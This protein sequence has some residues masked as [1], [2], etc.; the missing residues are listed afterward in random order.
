MSQPYVLNSKGSVKA[1]DTTTVYPP[2]D[3]KGRASRPPCKLARPGTGGTTAT[4]QEIAPVLRQRLLLAA[5]IMAAGFTIF[6]VRHLVTPSNFL[7]FSALDQV[8]QG[9]GAAALV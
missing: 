1:P 8:V 9:T 7:G 4:S 5:L 6:F 2:A 3:R